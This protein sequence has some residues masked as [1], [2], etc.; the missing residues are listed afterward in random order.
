MAKATREMKFRMES[1]TT[2]VEV[3]DAR[4]PFSSAN[5]NLEEVIGSKDRIIVLNKSDLA[6]ASVQKV[7]RILFR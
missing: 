1:V 7:S 6:D 2:V 3:R 4:I 5:P